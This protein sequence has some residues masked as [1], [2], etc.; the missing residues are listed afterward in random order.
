MNFIRKSCF[1]CTK[2]GQIK[3]IEPFEFDSMNKSV[4]SDKNENRRVKVMIR[5]FLHLFGFHYWDY[6]SEYP[7]P[8]KLYR[9]APKVYR[10]CRIC[11]KQQVWVWDKG[12]KTVWKKSRGN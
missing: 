4:G 3:I 12:W 7:D 8:T 10:Q 1:G 2:E 11:D 5:Y 6:F 9:P